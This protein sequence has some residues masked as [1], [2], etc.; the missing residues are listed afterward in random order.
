MGAGSGAGTGSDSG[1]ETGSDA[2]TAVPHLEQNL[3]LG[4]KAAPQFEQTGADAV[5]GI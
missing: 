3:A 1:T 4:F 5:S 2:G